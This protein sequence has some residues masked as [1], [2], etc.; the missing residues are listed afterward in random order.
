MALGTRIW[1]GSAA[2][3]WGAMTVLLWRAEF[4]PRH[5]VASSVPPGLVWRKMLSA[6]DHSTLEIRR[7][8]N[9][10]GSCVWRPDI[11]QEAALDA[12]LF[13]EED[14]IEGSIQRVDH[15]R[16][17]V[18]GTL[19]LPDFPSRLR[20]SSSARLDTNYV[21][22]RFETS[23]TMRP[24]TYQVVADRSGETL[25][26][27]IDAGADQLD[28]TF[29]FADFRNPQRFLQE[30]GGPMLPAMAG[31]MGVPLST[32]KLSAES[33]GL[34]WHARNDSIIVGNNRVRAYRLHTKLFDRWKVTIFVSPV[35]EILRA[36]FPGDIVLVNEHLTGLRNA[37]EHD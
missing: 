31:A 4:G 3:F 32:N 12:R 11:G 35:G 13:E 2:V 28:R 27:R 29:R 21:W 17:E 25:R 1:L 37:A 7:G 33:L 24:D 10:I 14:P 16:L 8:T 30:F 26:L 34:R 23:V 36:E 6:P 18:E 20:F 15:Y 5:Q 19:S 22:E 9:R